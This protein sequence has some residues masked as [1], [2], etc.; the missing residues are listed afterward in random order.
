MKAKDQPQLPPSQRAEAASLAQ[1]LHAAFVQ[2]VEEYLQ[3]SK[4]SLQEALA[5]ID[6]P[7]A[8][9]EYQR[10][11]QSAGCSISWRDLGRLA[12]RD[13]A[14]AAAQW[15]KIKQAALDELQSGKRAVRTIGGTPWEQAKFLAI[16]SGLADQL[17]PRGGVEWLLIDTLAQ[18]QESWLMW[19]QAMNGWAALGDGESRQACKDDLGRSTL[20]LTTA[21]AL[22][23]AAAMMDRFNKIV[24]RTLRALQE[25]RRFSPTVIVQNAGQVN[26]GGQQVNMRNGD[27]HPPRKT[28]R[29]R[30]K[31][32]ACTVAADRRSLVGESG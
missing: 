31:P 5:V 24:L 16:R 19:L 26:V 18:A 20:L 13:P 1:E 25:L 14:A 10:L 6:R 8:D 30:S 4:C 27:G 23:R 29:R 12:D 15:E 28:R 9:R 2:A 3:A 17:Q 32:V 11:L 21:E 22:D 7:L